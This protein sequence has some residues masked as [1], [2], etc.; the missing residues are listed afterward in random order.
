MES[1]LDKATSITFSSPK[2]AIDIFNNVF[3][4]PEA[5]TAEKERA[6]LSVALIA[7]RNED[8]G[9]LTNVFN[10]SREFL[11]SLPR[12]KSSKLVQT[13]IDR[14][15]CIPNAQDIQLQVCI[16]SIEWA[17]GDNRIYLLQ[18]LE[19][20]LAG[21]YLETKKYT[22]SLELIGKLLHDLK[23]VDDKMELVEVHLLEAKIYHALH[24]LAKS[25][26]ALTSARSSANSI[27]TPPPLQA[28]LD[29][30][31]GI[32]HSEEKDYKT[33]YS[34]FFE[35]LEGLALYF[36][37]EKALESDT[38]KISDFKSFLFSEDRKRLAKQLAE[39]QQQSLIYMMLCKIMLLAPEE[40]PTLLSSGK[41]AFKFRNSPFVIAMLEVAKAQKQRSLFN[42][43]KV[44]S[45]H[46]SLINGDP[47]VRTHL[48]LL[49]DTLLG[50]NLLRIIEPYSTV[51]LGH[52]AN[53]INLPISVVEF[54]LSQMILD[55]KLNGILDHGKGCLIIFD[56]S[57]DDK[58]YDYSLEIIKNMNNV[59][60]SLYSKT[61]LL[62]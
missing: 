7:E 45:E 37:P 35:T 13:L 57:E 6:L 44:L 11:S 62:N 14:F 1:Q 40:V 20:K 22:Q 23:K 46:R 30:Y 12:A 54:K 59:V 17:K 49:Y 36:V 51:E 43:E 53:Q 47:L 18:A 42:F 28:S 61:S 2:E 5:S 55:K 56:E 25:K 60:D 48:T 9:L 33:A 27:Y 19:K 21:M 31:S 41:T 38:S 26:A 29:L 58:L 50:E 8:V 15:S 24:N 3:S 39:R 52:I 32:L 34:Y 4:S 16:D 10:N